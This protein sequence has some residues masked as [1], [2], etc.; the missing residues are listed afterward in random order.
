MTLGAFRSAL[1]AVG[2]LENV[3]PLQLPQLYLQLSWEYI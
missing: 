3:R 1:T 2:Y